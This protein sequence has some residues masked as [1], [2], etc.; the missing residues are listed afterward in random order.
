LSASKREENVK[1]A[2]ACESC[3]TI[4]GFADRSGRIQ[5]RNSGLIASLKNT[6]DK[7]GRLKAI[8]KFFGT[9]QTLT[10]TVMRKRN[11]L[12]SVK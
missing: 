8:A 9:K 3:A 12:D 10:K 7:R 5:I 2:K 1:S 11:L 6:A 4:Q